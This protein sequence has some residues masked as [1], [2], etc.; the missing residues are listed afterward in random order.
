M[1]SITH[2]GKPSLRAQLVESA[3][4]LIAKDAA[5]RALY[6]RLRARTGGK[7]AI[8]PIARHMALIA[9]RV[10][11]NREPYRLGVWPTA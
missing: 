10:L 11:L 9:R 8:V 4:I 5:M 1:G 2:T 7:R 6:E 3:W